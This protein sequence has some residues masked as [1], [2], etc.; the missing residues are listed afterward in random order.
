M[1]FVSGEVVVS[2]LMEGGRVFEE[3]DEREGWGAFWERCFLG[4]ELF[5]VFFVGCFLLG[6]RK[7]R[8]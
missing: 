8:V 4:G 6:V 3:E 5:G 7:E 2:F 1:V